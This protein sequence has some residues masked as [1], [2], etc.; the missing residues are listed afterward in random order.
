MDGTW[1]DVELLAELL[2][3]ERDVAEGCFAASFAVVD[4]DDVERL[5]AI[6][7][8]H[9]RHVQTLLACVP[10]EVQT[11]HVL[12]ARARVRFARCRGDRAI[13]EAMRSSEAQLVDWIVA[14]VRAMPPKSDARELAEQM[15]RPAAI[16]AEWL[17]Q[18]CGLERGTSGGSVA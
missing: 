12:I 11:C 18:R 17:G 4:R 5:R 6:S 14:H 8:E 10:P 3:L 9:V 7:L 16:C 13:L 1:Q 15:A 2:E